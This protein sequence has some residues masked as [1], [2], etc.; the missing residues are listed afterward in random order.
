MLKKGSV[1]PYRFNVIFFTDEMKKTNDKSKETPLQSK[2]T[3]GKSHA[4]YKK[5]TNSLF[6]N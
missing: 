3:N 5:S 6:F 4:H 2:Q 1:A